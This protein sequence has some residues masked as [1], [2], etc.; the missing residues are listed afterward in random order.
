MSNALPGREQPSI[1]VVI[2]AFNAENCLE[3]AVQSVFDQTQ[4]PCEIVIVDDASTDNT[5]A[6]ADELAAKDGRIRLFALTVNSGPSAAR[7]A[8]LSLARGEWVVMLDAD[9]AFS[10]SRLETLAAAQSGRRVD[11]LLDNFFYYNAKIG[12]SGSTAFPATAE[13]ELID[14]Y[15]YTSNATPYGNGAD[16]GLLKPMFR[17][18][19]L[20]T[21]GLHYPEWSR[22]GEDFLLMFAALLAGARCALVK[23]PGYFYTTRDSGL[24]RTTVNYG[25]MVEHT[26]DLLRNPSVRADDRLCLLLHRRVTS[27]KRLSKRHLVELQFSTAWKERNYLH[28]ARFA[29]TDPNF[30]KRALRYCFRSIRAFLQSARH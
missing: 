15:R 11:V 17:R 4:P 26:L 22:H 8:G 18:K 6:I 16:W 25:M 14:I 24:S 21:Y 20:Q 5:L 29:V 28:L 7:N 27:L 10:P 2:P 1:S 9:D 23:T 12:K 30:A 13:I 3:R 19:F